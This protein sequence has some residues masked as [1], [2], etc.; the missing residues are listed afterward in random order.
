MPK[1][2]GPRNT[3][4]RPSKPH[5]E[6]F[7]ASIWTCAL[8]HSPLQVTLHV[9]APFPGNSLS[10]V[11]N[12]HFLSSHALNPTRS[13]FQPRHSIGGSLIKGT[14][15]LP[16]PHPMVTHPEPPYSSH[17]PPVS[18]RPAP[19]LNHFSL[20]SSPLPATP[21][22]AC[23]PV[24]Q[25]SAQLSPQTVLPS[26]PKLKQPHGATLLPY[27]AHLFSDFYLLF[28]GCL[29]WNRPYCRFLNATITNLL[30][31]FS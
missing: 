23:R 22:L 4:H 29:L 25:A 13:G 24:I 19:C 18:Y 11:P 26:P 21:L 14:D 12:S 16:G 31:D 27:V 20:R 28:T 15:D 2:T 3:E 30:Y 17:W 9:L 10:T 1:H 7:A 8:T 5:M 6:T